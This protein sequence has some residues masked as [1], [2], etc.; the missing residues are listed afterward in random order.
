MKRPVAFSIAG[1]DPGGGA[2]IQQD[3]KVFTV[4]GVWGCAAITALTVQNTTGVKAVYPIPG[5]VLKE[6][7]QAVMEDIRPR[8]VKTGMLSTMENVH[9]LAEVL[10]GYRDVFVV[11]DPVI[12]SK[13][14]RFLLEEN[15]VS[16]FMDE[17]FPLI[18]LITPNIPECERFTGV[19]PEDPEFSEKAILELY[20]M[21]EKRR[22]TGKNK[23]AVLLKGGHGTDSHLCTDILYVNGRFHFYESPRLASRH[24]HGTGCT[25]STAIAAFIARGN[26]VTDAVERARHVV[27]QA[28]NAGFALGSGTGPVDPL[29][30]G[31]DCAF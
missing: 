4:L 12:L 2:G 23:P 11:A 10:S 6:Q 1:S 27:F 13:N 26:N 17:L 16:V 18:D 21:M 19:S 14:G 8:V 15:A 29:V 20:S 30:L 5:S 31:P 9:V 25:L 28:I 3:L 7:V 22:L 24:T